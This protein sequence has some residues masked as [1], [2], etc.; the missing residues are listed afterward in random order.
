LADLWINPSGV[1][2]FGGAEL[3]R[4]MA[5]LVSQVDSLGA[6]AIVLEPVGGFWSGPLRIA[7]DLGSAKWA[8]AIKTGIL[9]SSP[10]V[11]PSAPCSSSGLVWEVSV[12]GDKGEGTALPA[13]VGMELGCDGG[14][15]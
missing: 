11:D 5:L 3:P 8:L 6:S 9:Y 2:V 13:L 1:D 12:N 10:V 15:N 4:K 14:N 7:S